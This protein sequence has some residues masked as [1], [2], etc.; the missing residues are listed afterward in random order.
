MKQISRTTSKSEFVA[1]S[2][3]DF[4]IICRDERR[5]GVVVD[6]VTTLEPAVRM[7]SLVFINLTKCFDLITL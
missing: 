3:A 2:F 1:F 4:H 7:Q 5:G 6:G